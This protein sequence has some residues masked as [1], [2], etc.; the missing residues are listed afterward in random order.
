[1]SNL[2]QYNWIPALGNE[3]AVCA[4]QVLAGA[5][6]LVL[7]GTFANTQYPG[8][9]NVLAI[10]G[11]SRSISLTSANNLAGVNFVVN[12]YQ[13]GV[14]VT[15]GNIVGPNANTVYLNVVIFDVV[16]SITANGAAAGISVGIGKIGF[17]PL[18]QFNSGDIS[19]YRAGSNVRNWA[20]SFNS[21]AIFSAGG[22]QLIPSGV[23]AIVADAT[24]SGIGYFTM[25]GN[26]PFFQ[27]MPAAAFY[28]GNAA[29]ANFLMTDNNRFFNQILVACMAGANDPNAQAQLNFR[30]S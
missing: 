24:K 12:G 20:L 2:Q 5:G 28:V 29:A 22:V 19:G 26:P 7:N 11:T 3:T 30:D 1:M 4:T 13:N 6:N 8:V 21:G 10:G 15:S 17:F 16:T 25:L 23:Y 14:A 27:P 9:I 18:V